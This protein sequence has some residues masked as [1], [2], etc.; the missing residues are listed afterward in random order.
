[1]QHDDSIEFWFAV[2]STYTYLTV[3]RIHQV[4]AATGV[5]LVWRPFNVRTIMQ[6]MDKIPFHTK[7]IKMA[8]MWRDIERP[9]GKYR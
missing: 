3:A 4:A 9:A 8:Y 7:P 1:M 2:G 5:R 6:E